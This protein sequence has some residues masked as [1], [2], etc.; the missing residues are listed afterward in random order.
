MPPSRP[1]ARFWDLLPPLLPFPLFFPP[2]LDALSEFAIEAAR[3]LLNRARL[4]DIDLRRT[5]FGTVHM[6]RVLLPLGAICVWRAFRVWR[7]AASPERW[8][9]QS[10]RLYR[11]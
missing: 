8:L 11:W 2:L 5:S 1:A 7:E 10:I 3:C 4:Q 6:R 9:A